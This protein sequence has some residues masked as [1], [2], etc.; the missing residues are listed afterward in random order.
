MM[1]APTAF[2]LHACY[3]LLTYWIICIEEQDE[4]DNGSI[5]GLAC[6]SKTCHVHD[7][8]MR[9]RISCAREIRKLK[10]IVR[11]LL[12]SEISRAFS[13]WGALHARDI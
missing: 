8:C 11:V 7:V 10:A 1:E 13:E 2:D 12:A 5:N 9:T 6:L 4:P 3:I